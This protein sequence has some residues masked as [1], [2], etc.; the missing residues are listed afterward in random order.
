MKTADAVYEA[1]RL[2]I[3]VEKPQR[4]TDIEDAWHFLDYMLNTAWFRRR[5]PHKARTGVWLKTGN[6]E[7]AFYDPGQNVICLPP[8][9]LN[10]LTLLH[11]VAHW[12]CRS[13][14][15]HCTEFR[16][17]Y[18]ALVKRFMGRRSAHTLRHSLDA[19]HVWP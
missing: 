15:D 7:F 18:H 6:W 17:I 12:L 3:L 4:F 2:A 11:E 5:W 1:E 14:D 9:A 19:C 16:S 8:W 13:E 10:S